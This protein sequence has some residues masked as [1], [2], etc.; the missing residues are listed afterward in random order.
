MSPFSKRLRDF[1]HVEWGGVFGD[2]QFEVRTKRLRAIPLTLGSCAFILALQVIQHSGAAGHDWVNRVGGVYATLPWWEALLRTPLSLFVPDPSLP[3]WGLIAQVVI[4]FGIAE[5]TVGRVH[6]LGIGFLATLAGTS[7]ARYSLSV[8]PDG[9][10]G[11][12]VSTLV[13]RDTGPSAAVVALG[14]YVACRYRAWWTLGVL[15]LAMLAEVVFIVNLA[16]F[17]HLTAIVATLLLCGLE[18]R[19]RRR[20]EAAAVRLP[21]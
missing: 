2:I 21:P 8:G 10:L 5:M 16:G 9:F 14:V 4:V 1:A 6:T 17:E 3:V 15:I 12:P 7:F 13:V 20:R 11:L 18:G 19:L